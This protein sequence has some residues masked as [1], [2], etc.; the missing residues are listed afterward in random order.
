MTLIIEPDG[1]GGLRAHWG[2]IPLADDPDELPWRSLSGETW[3]LQT[4]TWEPW[5][6]CFYCGARM[7]S[8]VRCDN[9]IAQA[10]TAA[11][12]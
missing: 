3:N 2:I 6:E 12:P 4:Q 5:R 8:Q 11:Q 1:A 9:C 7:T 10:V